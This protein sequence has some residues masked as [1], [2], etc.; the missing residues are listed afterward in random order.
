MALSENGNTALIGGAG[1]NGKVGAAWVF[2][3]TAGVWTQESG[4]LTGT[5]GSGQAGSASTW[6]CRPTATRP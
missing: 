6:R 1:D 5:G 2:T 3:R 4:K